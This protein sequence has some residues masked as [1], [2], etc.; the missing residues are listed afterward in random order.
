MGV[1]C[2]V[3][4]M[5]GAALHAANRIDKRT[6]KKFRRTSTPIFKRIKY[7]EGGYL[8][9][10][11]L[12]IGFYREKIWITS[13]S[14]SGLSLMPVFDAD[15]SFNHPR[16]S[17][18]ETSRSQQLSRSA[19]LRPAKNPKTDSHPDHRSTDFRDDLWE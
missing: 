1:W 17:E 4:G 5:T 18:I 13:L 19:V 7:P 8:I 3:A 9:F 14:R 6:L 2:C 10:F 15:S 16:S 11:S 12:W